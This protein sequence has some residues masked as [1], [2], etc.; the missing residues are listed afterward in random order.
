MKIGHEE[1]KKLTLGAIRLEKDRDGVHFHRF[2]EEERS[3]IVKPMHLVRS[4]SG[5]GIVLD[6]STDA[7]RICFHATLTPGS[8]HNRGLFDFD[9]EGVLV[10]HG[11]STDVAGAPE[12]Y[13]DVGLDGRPHRYTLHFPHLAHAALE[14]FELEGATFVEPR[15]RSRRIVF[16]GDS[17]TQG[18]SA[19]HPELTYASLVAAAFDAES[20]NLAVGGDTF[21]P[22][23]VRSA[24]ADAP[25]PDLVICAYGT[26]DWSNCTEECFVEKANDFF[27]S[28]ADVYPGVPVAALQPIWRKTE[29]RITK[30]GSFENARRIVAEA[31][32][33][34]TLAQVIPGDKMVPQ[35][36]EFFA[37][38]SLHPN[39][40]GFSVYARN[41]VRE[42]R[43]RYPFL[44]G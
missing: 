35:L 15:R 39:D 28:L 2:T 30:A 21:H 8:S 44:T 42:L 3:T 4:R 17:I 12:Y 18:Y 20:R 19:V 33:R 25:R 9:C 23:L 31:A 13:F 40:L 5:S 16:Y 27:A 1:F 6:F 34:D 43:R 14:D 22:E 41:L 10:A 11:G 7:K 29:V 37:D 38:G 36:A 26:N 24:P 32:K